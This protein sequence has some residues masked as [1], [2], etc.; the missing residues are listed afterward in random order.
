[1]RDEAGGTSCHDV[2]LGLTLGRLVALGV[3]DSE[4]VASLLAAGLEHVHPGGGGGA[5][6]VPV[7][8]QA[9]ALLEFRE[10]IFV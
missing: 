6:E 9:L 1:M 10:H 5:G 7:R 4:D 2:E 8:S 3:A